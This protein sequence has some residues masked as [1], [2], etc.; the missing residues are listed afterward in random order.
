MLATERRRIITE[1]VR[2][3]QSVPVATF[4]AELGVSIETVRRDLEQLDR[5]GQVQRVRGGAVLP[6]HAAVEEPSFIARK[7]LFA[8]EKREIA[9]LAAGMIADARTVFIDLGTTALALAETLA[10]TF[11]GTVVTPSMRIAQVLCDLPSVT[12]LMPGGIVRGGDIFV[13]GAT[14]RSFLS[15]IYP[16]VAFISTGGLDSVAG[17]TDFDFD[18]ADTKKLVIDNSARS[19][20]LV[21]SSKVGVRAPFR[22]CGADAFDAVLTDSRVSNSAL[23]TLREQGVDVL[24]GEPSILQ[25][26][27]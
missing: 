1:M 12:V 2:E 15:E 19:Y 6:G 16:D 14:A 10:T 11:T 17:V 20:A 23:T 4:A 8:A 26:S 18:Q 3:A 21:D 27:V 22:V 9:G 24:V 5:S 25:E 7:G 13:S